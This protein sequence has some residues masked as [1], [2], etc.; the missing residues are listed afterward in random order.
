MLADLLEHRR[1]AEHA[2][3]LLAHHQFDGFGRI[4]ALLCDHCGSTVQR[5]EQ[6]L[7]PAHP[8]EGH[9][10]KGASGM[11]ARHAHSEL[12]LDLAD[13]GSVGMHNGL[14]IGA[15]TRRVDDEERVGRAYFRFDCREQFVGELFWPWHIELDVVSPGAATANHPN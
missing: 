5:A 1:P 4:E 7:W 11:R 2:G 9:R 12:R 6:I 3:A 13:S 8:E 15:R 10:R 14:W